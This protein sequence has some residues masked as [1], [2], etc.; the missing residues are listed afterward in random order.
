MAAAPVDVSG[1]P[2]STAAIGCRAE[3]EVSAIC[4]HSGCVADGRF[5]PN[6]G[7][8]HLSNLTDPARRNSDPM[9]LS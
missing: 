7:Q 9:K 1:R 6:A 4:S 8:S 5:T 3:L 2:P